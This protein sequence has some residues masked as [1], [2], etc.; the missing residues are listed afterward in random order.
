MLRRDTQQ[1]RL[2]T[3]PLEGLP[4]FIGYGEGIGQFGRFCGHN[5]TIFGFSSEMW[6]L[7]EEDAVI[8]I[9]VNRL[10]IDDE[11][12]STNLFLDISKVLFS[13]QINW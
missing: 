1:E 13:E 10:D 8:V 5:G 2:E 11:S 9:N 3:Q 6:Y 7:P 12:K 4:S